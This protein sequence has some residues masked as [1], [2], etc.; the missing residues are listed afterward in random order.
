MGMEMALP[1]EWVGDLGQPK[2]GKQGEILG[3]N[4]ECVWVSY[5]EIGLPILRLL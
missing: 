5:S 4:R 2:D 3:K 1:L